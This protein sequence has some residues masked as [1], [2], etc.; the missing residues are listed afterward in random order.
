MQ[1]LIGAAVLA[2]WCA[3]CAPAFGF[4]AAVLYNVGGKLDKSFNESAFHGVSAMRAEKHLSIAEYEPQTDA[5]RI[6]MLRLAAA[7]ADLV[8]AVG[9]AYRDSL[10]LVAR[11]YPK[12]RFAIV[13]EIVALPNVLSIRF[14]EQEGAFL[15]GIAA[16]LASKS[17]VVGFV[18]GMD[19]ALIRRFQA[20]YEQGARHARPDTRVVA[21]MI[22]SGVEAFSDPVSGYLLAGEEIAAGA[23]VVFAAAGGS[24]LGVYQKATDAKVLA[25]GVDSDQTYLFP[26]TMLTSAVKNVGAAVAHA[27]NSASDNSW[28]GGIQSLGLKEG[29]LSL[30]YGRHNEAL[31]TPTITAAVAAARQAIVEDRLHVAEIPQTAAPATIR[32]DF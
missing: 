13:D 29:A 26:G 25:V 1:R 15:A 3:V 27:L 7:S 18:G 4:S 23:D 28:T 32:G 31:M 10:D 19:S 16:A 22:G 6:P 24:G 20:G 12:T 8:V 5:D 17:H 2:L 11:E 21:R 30:A 14:R 9:F